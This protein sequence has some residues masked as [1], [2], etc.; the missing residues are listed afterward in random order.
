VTRFNGYGGLA[1]VVVRDLAP[2]AVGAGLD[3]LAS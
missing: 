3:T 2:V 1:R